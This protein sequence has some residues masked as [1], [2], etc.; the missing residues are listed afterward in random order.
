MNRWALLLW[1]T[2]LPLWAGAQTQGQG[3]PKPV[4]PHEEIRTLIQA[5]KPKAALER[6][7]ALIEKSPR[8]VQARF[9][10]SVLLAELGQTQEAITTLEALTQ[11]FPELPE[12]HNNLGVLLAARGQYELA[13]A[14]LERALMAEPSYLTAHENLGDLYVAM[15][16]QA[17]RQA[18]QLDPKSA[19]LQSKLKQTTQLQQAV[20]PTGV[21]ASTVLPPTSR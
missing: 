9:V 2:G 21:S 14:A 11:E 10:R 7:E 6:T 16:A 15:A 5:G 18:T 3:T 8:D 1:V 13:R 4:T 19:K 20:R 12:P 17:Y